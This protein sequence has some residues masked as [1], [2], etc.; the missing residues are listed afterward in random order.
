MELKGW[1][2]QLGG[3]VMLSQVDC[4]VSASADS[5]GSK[6][7][8]VTEPE[9]EAEVF[10]ANCKAAWAQHGGVKGDMLANVNTP[11]PTYV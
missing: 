5:W 7:E 1:C 4:A 6:V 3:G 8:D 9:Q 11:D 2:F 10:L